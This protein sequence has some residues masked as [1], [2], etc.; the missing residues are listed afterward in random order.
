MFEQI[1]DEILLEQEKGMD[2]MAINESAKECADLLIS[3]FIDEM[4]DK[5]EKGELER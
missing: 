4:I 1:I 2:V 3:Q 5:L